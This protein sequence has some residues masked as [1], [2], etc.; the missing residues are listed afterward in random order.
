LEPRASLRREIRALPRPVWIL[1]GG[2]FVNRLGSFVVPFLVIY[3]RSL[4]YSPAQA[5][6]AASA[7]GGGALAS[8]AVG[9]WFADRLGR[10]R[11]IAL[12]MF[13]TAVTLLVMWRMRGLVA[14]STLGALLGLVSDL[15]RPAAS[16]FVADF[17]PE[18][19][20]VPAF[21]LYRLAVNAGWAAGLALAGFLAERSY[22]WL[23]VGDALTAAGFGGVALVLLPDTGR[24]R[25]TE[26]RR[27]ELFRAL[28]ARPRFLLFLVSSTLATFVYFQTTSTYA[29][30]VRDSGFSS[31]TYGLLL[32]LN[33][34][35]I[36]LVELPISG[37]GMRFPARR[38][39]AIGVLLTGAG[40]AMLA[41]TPTLGLLVAS[42]LVLTVGEM[43]T[44]PV[45][46][47]YV[48]DQAPAG[49]QGRFQGAWAFTYGLGV[50]V[51]PA[52]GTAVYQRSAGALWLGCAGLI[53]A[54]AALAP[55]WPAE[56]SRP[57]VPAPVPGP[58]IPR[59]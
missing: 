45:A 39:I 20:R 16:A 30:F 3:V 13:G 34:I 22:D 33:G 6:L 12:S 21:A 28:R 8:A 31:A 1:C 7:Y 50:V 37:I 42:M 27:G 2:A 23:F 38:V 29:L 44:Q 56:R 25:R 48:S 24:A 11:T 19:R 18:G 10:R 52:L 59:V 55:W 35:L 17:V 46:A 15:Y 49:L 9:G 58:D 54:A 53:M 43:V 14:I 41:A 40:F 51:G 32:S 26:E 47:G 57:V 5:G 36:V 4:G